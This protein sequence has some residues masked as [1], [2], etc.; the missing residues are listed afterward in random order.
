M[1]E[2]IVVAKD[3]VIRRG[4]KCL[5]DRVSLGLHPNQILAIVGPNGAGKSTLLR[6]LLG[7]LP[8]SSGSITI[9]GQRL[10]TLSPTARALS[11]AYVPQQSALNID[12]TVEAVVRMGRFAHHQSSRHSETPHQVAIEQAI[13]QCELQGCRERSYLSLSGGERA[14]V[15]L[16]RA[17]ATQAPVLLLDEPCQNLDIA[18]QLELLSYLRKLATCGKA[19]AMVTHDL[20]Q[21]DGFADQV[22]LMKGG[23]PEALVDPT[24]GSIKSLLESVFQIRLVAGTAFGYARL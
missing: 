1:S 13:E 15:L 7:V 8:L 12:L 9:A 21:L 5:V 4:Q 6:G 3:V 16:A 20:N 22:L 24:Q 10:E 17:L 19:V 23:K 11:L 14:R 2:A 18:H